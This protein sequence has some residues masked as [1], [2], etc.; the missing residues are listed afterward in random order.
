MLA[1]QAVA[2]VDETMP[3]ATD[4]VDQHQAHRR[5]YPDRQGNRDMPGVQ[6]LR[7]AAAMQIPAALRDEY[8]DPHMNVPTHVWLGEFAEK[9]RTGNCEELADV[10]F[11]WLVVEKKAPHVAIYNL[12][13]GRNVIH[14][15][16]MI[17]V[18]CPPPEYE[19]LKIAQF[20]AAWPPT[21]VWCDPWRREWF[22]IKDDYA[23]RVRMIIRDCVKFA[24][25]GGIGDI[26]AQPFVLVCRAYSAG[27]P[28][29]PPS[30]Q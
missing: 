18:Q 22:E 4:N 17:G 27:Q 30:A 10:A 7:F 1:E 25:V 6:A 19:G 8:D 16:V 9:H 13:A 2:Y 11:R 24:R 15:F 14:T 3:V 12:C 29:H 5:N 20:P 28:P 23:R 26:D 21:A